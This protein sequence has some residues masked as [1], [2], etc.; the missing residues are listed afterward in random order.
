[1]VYAT[2]NI[3]PEDNGKTM[4]LTANCF[5]DGGNPVLQMLFY[6]GASFLKGTETTITSTEFEEY[7]LT[8]T[9]PDNT[10]IVHVRLRSVNTATTAYWDNISLIIQ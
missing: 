4:I 7:S 1:M 5:K 8:Y 2:I 10:T 9:I 6:N 3:S